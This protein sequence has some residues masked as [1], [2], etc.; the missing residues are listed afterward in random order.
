[1]TIPGTDI[2][3]II[4]KL[5]NKINNFIIS[6]LADE[7]IT[8]LAPSHGAIFLVLYHDGPQPML[9][10]SDKINRDK[11]TMTVLIR[12]LE[13]LGYVKR[14]PDAVDKRSSIIHLTEKG[15]KFRATFEQISNEL[16]DRIWG[17]TLPKERSRLDQELK[18][19]IE[20]L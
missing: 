17:D 9:A 5:R 16:I 12:K 10:L 15:F 8:G 11:S 14:E 13:A 6:R 2:A 4:A 1:M 3:N 7:G 20:R 18:R 19:M